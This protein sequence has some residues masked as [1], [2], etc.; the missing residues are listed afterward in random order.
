MLALGS[1]TKLLRPLETAV[2]GARSGWRQSR[3][4]SRR[5]DAENVLP[6]TKGSQSEWKSSGNERK[7]LSV[8]RVEGRVDGANFS[9]FQS[10]LESGVEP[11]AQT[12]VVD[13]EGVVFISSAGLRVV[14][15]LGKQLR[16]RGRATG[17]LLAQRLDSP[18]IRGKWI[19]QNRADSR[20]RNAGH[21]C[22][23]HRCGAGRGRAVG[24]LRNEIDFDIVGDNLKD[25]AGFTLEKARV[26]QRLH[27]VAGKYA[28]GGVDT[29]QRRLVAV[30]RAVEARAP[31]APA[32]DVRR[33]VE[34]PGRRRRFR[35]RLTRSAGRT[36][37][38]RTTVPRLP[39]NEGPAAPSR[40]RAAATSS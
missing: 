20:F 32:T 38:D 5:P 7:K 2:G 31:V 15:M 37:F 40:Y 19:R 17:D 3:C 28:R 12:V 26:H 33:R 4:R 27:A 14:L 18:H 13:F 1:D 25:I 9:E 11:D 35:P 36:R 8:A 39:R 29:H 23:R 34:R 24:T 21:R 30:R 16:K 10:I 6:V 22:A